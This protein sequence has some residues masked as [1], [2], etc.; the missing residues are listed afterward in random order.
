MNSSKP[1]TAP[2]QLR[3]STKSITTAQTVVYI[4]VFSGLSALGGILKI[5]SPIG[6]IALDSAPGYFCA[7][8]FNPLLGGIIGFVGHLSSALTAGFPLGLNHLYIACHMFL[9]CFTFGFLARRIGR[10]LGL[11]VACVVAAALNGVGSPLLLVI[12]PFNSMPLSI[13]TKIMPI[14][15]VASVANILLAALAYRAISKLRIPGL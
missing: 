8:Y 7:V 13:A 3:T 11:V 6:S 12:S 4:V 5:P 14:L 2:E 9:W 1:T 15:V 10:L